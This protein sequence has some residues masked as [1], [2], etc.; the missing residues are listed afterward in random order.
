MQLRNAV[1]GDA[2][3]IAGIQVAASL[4]A[5]RGIVPEGYFSGFTVEKR[6]TVWGQLIAATDAIEQIIIGVEGDTVRGFV[7]V[8]RSRE[9]DLSE[10]A[11]ELYA[12]YVDPQCWR[13]GVGHQLLAEGLTRLTRLDLKLVTL[14]VL[15]AN[16]Q[17]CQ[18]Y[19][20]R[21]WTEDE[22]A[23]KDRQPTVRYRI[24]LAMPA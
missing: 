6:A 21:G 18:F 24:S 5:Y 8:G 13:Q 3:A 15:A 1:Q 23:P 14:R 10:R 7:H 19:E 11:A 20:K 17:A 9:P 12:L 22:G 4:A 16:S 2:R